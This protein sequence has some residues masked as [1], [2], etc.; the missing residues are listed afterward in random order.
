MLNRITNIFDDSAAATRVADRPWQ[1]DHRPGMRLVWLMALLTFP[2]VAVTG[3]L[4]YLQATLGEDFIEPTAQTSELTERIPSRDGRILASDGRVLASDIQRFRVQVHYRWLESPPNPVWLRR[5]ALSQLDRAERRNTARVDAETE[6]ILSQRKRMWRDLATLADTSAHDLQTQ[7]TRIQRQVE[8]IVENVER[9]RQQPAKLPADH[10][11]STNTENA[12]WW[13]TAWQT[14]VTT[15]TTSPE[16]GQLDPIVVREELQYHDLLIDVSLEAA[17]AIE[18]HPHRFPGLEIEVRSER[19][20]AQKSLAAHVVGSRLPLDDDRLAARHE[21]F[22]DGDPLDYQRHNRIGRTG[23]ERSYDRF[24]HGSSGRRTIV[25]NRH[26]EI[27]SSTIT[28]DPVIGRDI[29]LTLD[30][31]LQDRVESLLAEVLA[32]SP[33]TPAGGRALPVPQGACLIAIDVRTGAVLA[34][35]SAPTF[36]ISQLIHPSPQEWQR[37][38][39]DPRRPL[40]PRITRMALPPGSVFKTLAAVAAIESGKIDPDAHHHCQGYLD[41]PDRHRCYIYRHYGVGH[42]DLNLSDALCRSCNVYFFQAARTIGPGPLVAWADRFG[43]GHPTGIDLP[44]EH[45]GHL[46]TPSGRTSQRWYPG[47]TLGLAIGQSRLTTTPLQIAR[48]MAVVANDGYLVTPHVVR[49]ITSNDPSQNNGA[50]QETP[51]HPR[52][53]LAGLHDGTLHRIREGLAKVVSHPR[54]TGYKRVRLDAVAIAGKTGTAEVGGG[55]PDHAWFAGYVPADRPRIAFA[56]VLENAGSGGQAAGPV[57]RRFIESLL[58][59]GL[60]PPRQLANRD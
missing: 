56:V 60:I 35:A 44:G 39:D 3:R 47:D 52:R 54:G 8:R 48:I 22:P 12:A 19:V 50:F 25:R 18:A 43:F 1:V 9:R 36:D 7:R 58:E 42:G 5:Q 13:Q 16:R 34:A 17:A 27:I 59:L 45:T 26:G 51:P 30:M 57:A 6:V 11:A 32:A 15:L 33:T 10:V 46:P 28:R 37:L 53:R 21:R 38:L 29:T 41:R 4:I 31:P 14:L 23:V 55:K 24:L 20:Y 2:F 40:F 49:S